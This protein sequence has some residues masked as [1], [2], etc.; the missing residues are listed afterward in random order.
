M[1]PIGLVKLEGEQKQNPAL[2]GGFRFELTATGKDAKPQ[3]TKAAKPFDQA[4]LMKQA[5]GGGAGPGAGGPGAAGPGA[6]GPGAPG[7]KK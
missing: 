7:P 6:A 3:I 4:A 1:L 2:K 5:T